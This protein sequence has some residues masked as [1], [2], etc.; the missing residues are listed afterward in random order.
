MKTKKEVL[1][2]ISDKRMSDDTI[3]EIV[4]ALFVNDYEDLAF[5]VKEFMENKEVLTTDDFVDWFND[6]DETD[7][8]EDC[9]FSCDECAIL[10]NAEKAIRLY[11]QLPPMVKEHYKWVIEMLKK[12]KKDILNS[13]K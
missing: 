11:E 13:K 4:N 12:I 3:D 10:M 5:A 1:E 8:E 7:C 2:F 6:E 9:I